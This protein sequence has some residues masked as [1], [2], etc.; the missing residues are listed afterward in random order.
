MLKIIISIYTIIRGETIMIN[1]QKLDTI[2]A[3][4]DK[5]S[6]EIDKHITTLKVLRTNRLRVCTNLDRLAIDVLIKKELMKIESVAMAMGN[7]T[8][9]LNYI[10]HYKENLDNRI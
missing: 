8:N 1:Q 2:R 5:L 7:L 3:E 6:S 4:R 10:D 9:A